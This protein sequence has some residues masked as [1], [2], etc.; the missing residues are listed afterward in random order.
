MRKLFIF[1]LMLAFGIASE[2]Q[3]MHYNHAATA[4]GT[5]N[6]FPFNANPGPGKKVQFVI[7][8]GEFSLPTP[9]PAGNNITSLWFWANAA[10]TATY[11]TLTIRMATVPTTTFIATGAWYGGPMTTVLAQNTAVT[12]TGANTWVSIPLTTPFLYD[13]TM[14]IIIEVFHCGFTGTGFNLRQ[15]GFGDR[16]SVV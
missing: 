6:V 7:T 9:A 3:P 10:G 5:V 2:A 12:P 1:F 8:P 11:T 16:K 15:L 13:P 4:G 14:N